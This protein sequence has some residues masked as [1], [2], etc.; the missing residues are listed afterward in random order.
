MLRDLQAMFGSS[1]KAMEVALV[2]YGIKPAA[3]IMVASGRLPQVQGC[4]L[5]QQLCVA[6]SDF[7]VK[8]E[9][10]SQ[11][12]AKPYSDIGATLPKESAQ[13]GCFFVYIA[14]D[15]EDSE[16]AKSLENSGDH[17]GFGKILGYPGCCIKFFQGNADL[18]E[19]MHGDLTLLSLKNS[20]GFRFPLENNICAR[21][22]DISLLSHFPCSFSC[23]HSREIAAKN[24]ALIKKDDAQCAAEIEEKLKSAV[25]YTQSQGVFLLRNPELKENRLYYKGLIGTKD[26]QFCQTLRCSD[27]I[28]VHDK[29]RINIQGLEMKGVGAM[30][31]SDDGGEDDAPG[32]SSDNI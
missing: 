28:V 32:K 17:A 9:D 23:K 13:E 18:L 16:R 20:P 2:A 22:I 10:I 29:N 24:L 30:V 1:I 8:K 31:F 21:H 7:K 6:V 5:Q 15:K 3:R 14:R 4:L 19:K 26:N 11:D 27:F 25:I 12:P